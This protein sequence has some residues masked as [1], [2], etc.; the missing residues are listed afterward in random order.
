MGLYE[1]YNWQTEFIT[2]SNQMI[3]TF[4]SRVKVVT[5]LNDGTVKV[6][7][8]G[9]VIRSLEGRFVS[10]YEKLLLEVAGDAKKLNSFS[11]GK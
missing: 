7:K 4:S 5:N 6:L 10:D 3:H 8:D 9:S 11:N 1:N 2:A